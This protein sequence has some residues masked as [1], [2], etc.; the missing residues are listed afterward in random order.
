MVRFMPRYHPWRHLRDEHPDV[1][2][3]FHVPVPGGVLGWWHRAGLGIRP[4][5]TQAQRRSTIAHELVHLERGETCG[6][7]RAHLAG[8]ELQVEQ[9][10]AERLMPLDELLDAIQ[11]G[12]GEPD[13]DE[14]QV[15]PVAL[16][17]RV[18]GLTDEERHW[19]DD[20][21]EERSR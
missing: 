21:L 17:V 9:Q 3:T 7:S 20:K 10:A 11:W 8:H 19:I 14:L 5:L 1:H 12:Q 4:G 13:P 16:L 2:V 18:R 15:D 6:M